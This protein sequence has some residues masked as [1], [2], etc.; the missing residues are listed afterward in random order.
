MSLCGSVARQGDCGPSSTATA[1]MG[2]AA[3][4]AMS[5]GTYVLN[6]SVW[7]D[8]SIVEAYA[9]DGEVVLVALT[10]FDAE[11]PGAEVGVWASGCTADVNVTVS[12]VR[13][14][15]FAADPG[16]WVPHRP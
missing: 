8:R 10:G 16:P 7:V 6:A 5:E 9:N 15:H 11:A 1:P 3:A 4:A 2:S 14:A 12:R 13:S